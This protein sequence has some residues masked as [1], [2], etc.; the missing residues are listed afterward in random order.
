MTKSYDRRYFEQWYRNPETRVRTRAE[1]RRRIALVLGIAEEVLRRP[2]RSLL[3]IG[4]GEGAWALEL[5]RLRPSLVYTGVDSSRYAVERFGRARNLHLGTLR[6]LP[7]IDF[8]REGFDVIVCSDVMHYVDDDEIEEALPWIVDH[9]D[10]IAYLSVFTRED[11][12]TGDLTGW[13]E[14]PASW[15]RSKFRS[16]GLT[17]CGMQCWLS[18]LVRESASAMDRCSG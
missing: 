1:L 2:V 18:P 17:S 11:D 13:I 5:R 4:C 15:Y 9:L 10:G 12:P 3:D 6:D 14:R 7:H 8:G 16:A